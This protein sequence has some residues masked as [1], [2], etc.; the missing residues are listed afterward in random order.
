MSRVQFQL[1][2]SN[3]INWT[4][5]TLAQGEPGYALDTRKFK[6]GDGISTWDSLKQINSTVRGLSGTTGTTII[7]TETSTGTK[8]YPIFYSPATS[9]FIYVQ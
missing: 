5:I 2:R 1:R 8:F 9:E 3:E 6:I 4:G 7:V